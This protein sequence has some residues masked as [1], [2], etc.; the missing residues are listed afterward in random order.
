MLS[1][2]RGM[3]LMVSESEAV[4]AAES[5]LRRVP[6]DQVVAWMRS[7]NTEQALPRPR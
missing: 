7:G 1:K 4:Q 3:T 6:H 2:I 5:D